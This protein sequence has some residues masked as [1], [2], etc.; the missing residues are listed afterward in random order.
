MVV[1]KLI[2]VEADEEEADGP[3]ILEASKSLTASSTAS[4]NAEP[5]DAVVM[6]AAAHF[7]L[8]VARVDFFPS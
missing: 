6:H 7:V 8:S 5:E 4:S 1:S 2:F 3:D